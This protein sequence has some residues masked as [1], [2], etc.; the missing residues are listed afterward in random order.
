MG[1]G[2]TTIGKMLADRLKW[3]FYDG[4]D[5]HTPQS[6]AKMRAGV[7]LTD[8]DRAPWLG[9]LRELI[10]VSLGQGGSIIL[11]CSALK[12]SCR[13]ILGVDQ[14]RLRTIYLK[15][16]YEVLLKRIALRSHQ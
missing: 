4:D 6:I 12:K 1:C 10:E 5:F 2:K 16:P 11:A 13:D 7:A 14:K 8:E 3:P 15:G 9:T